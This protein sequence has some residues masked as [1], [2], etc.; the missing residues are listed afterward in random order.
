MYGKT[1]SIPDEQIYPW[2]ELCTDITG[3]QLSE[4]EKQLDER[5]VNPRDLK[6]QLARE[7]VKLYHDEDAAQS[8]EAHFQTVIVNKDL[9][10]EIPIAVISE[11]TTILE[12]LETHQLVSS[13][14]EARRLIDQGAVT[15]D[16]HSIEDQ[17]EEIKPGAVQIIKVGKRRFLKV[18]SPSEG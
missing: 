5:S 3:E 12:L 16:G 10:E 7:I 2:F 13:K 4:I 15:I 11:S 6:R 8:A 9:P 17:L 14:G 18:V 1:M